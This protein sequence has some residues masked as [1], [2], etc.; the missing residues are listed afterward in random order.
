[1]ILKVSE[2][3]IGVFLGGRIFD[4]RQLYIIFKVCSKG[5]GNEADLPRF[6][7]KSVR[8]WS[9]PYTTF[10]AVPILASNSQRYS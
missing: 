7:H 3:V 8:H 1:M 2:N 10:R 5:H 9:L 6:L 4:T